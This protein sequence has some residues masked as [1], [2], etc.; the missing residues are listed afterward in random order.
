MRPDP[1]DA[2][3]RVSLRLLA[4][5]NAADVAGVLAVWAADGVLMPPHHPPVRGRAA[6]AEYFRAVFARA[7]LTFRFTSSVVE[8]LG[9]G[10]VERLSYAARAIPRGGGEAVAEEGTGLHVYRRAPDGTWLLAQDIWHSD[11]PAA[12]AHAADRGAE[13]RG[14]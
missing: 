10:A 5:V 12:T 4:A 14:A 1:E 2:I 6:L 9:A 3:R 8:V 7:E 13:P 11:G